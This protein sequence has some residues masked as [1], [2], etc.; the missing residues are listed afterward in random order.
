[1]KPNN[2]NQSPDQSAINENVA[3]TSELSRRGFLAGSS[4]ILATASALNFAPTA[5]A[6]SAP[7]NAPAPSL[8]PLAPGPS[9]TAPPPIEK[10]A[11]GRPQPELQKGVPQPPA[12]RV[13]FAVVGLGNY[14]LN[15]I[16][17]SFSQSKSAKL[18]ALVSGNRDKAARIGADYGI[19]TKNLYSYETFDQLRDN[20]QVQ[21]IYVILPV[22][23][24][25]EYAIRAAG[26][27]KHVLCEKP[28]APTVAECQQMI[29]AAK[30]AN[31]QL[32]I[33][34]RAQYEP[35]NQ[36]AIRICRS[37]EL[38]AISQITSD[39]GRQVDPSIPSDQ[40]RLQKALAGGGALFDIGIYA[41]N[42]TRYLS[43]EEPTEISAM[44][45]SPPDDP[46]F[47]EVEANVAWTMRFPSGI[48][49]SCTTSYNYQETKRFRVFAE[50][51]WLDLDPATDYY[52]HRMTIE[53]PAPPDVAPKTLR[54]ERQIP[55]GNQFALMLD[56]MAEV[57]RTNTPSRTPGEEGLRDVR[58]M[59]LIYEAARSGRRIDAR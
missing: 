31:R 36:E 27:G 59:N 52:Q 4:A 15:Q 56:H 43:G 29:A 55:E 47:R 41:L 26:L 53:R 19:E 11:I 51:G 40:W 33:G 3:T 8:E 22:G 38:G 6:Q 24:H 50:R 23:L 25:A 16:L 39:H 34:Y 14:A 5:L 49:A 17:P 46:R 30:A 58:L 2:S 48:L 21:V 7:T 45:W 35:F 1:M 12:Q 37:G 20:P 44:Q 18:V 13:G 10:R 9:K 54:Q 28:M 32:M 42:A 57:A